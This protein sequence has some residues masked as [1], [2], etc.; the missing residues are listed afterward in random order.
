MEF[1]G[2][3]KFTEAL[4]TLGETSIEDAVVALSDSE[5]LT[6]AGTTLISNLASGITD[7]AGTITTAI[8]TICSTAV[9]DLSATAS[10]F[11]GVGIMMSSNLA[12][13]ISL[14]SFVV[15]HAASNLG[16]SA[17]S[18]VSV[19]GFYTAGGNAAKGFANGI[20]DNTWRATAKARAMAQ[21]AYEAAKKQLDINSP[22]R[23]FI[24]LAGSVPEG[25]AKGI[26]K[27]GGLVEDSSISMAN[28]AI[29]STK[30]AIS[31]IGDFIS[32]DV[33]TQPT[34]RPVIDLTDVR[35]G[36]NSINRMFAMTPSLKTLSNV[37]SISRMMN[38]SQNGTNND[39]ISAIKDLGSRLGTST[40][41]TY[42]INGVTYD[43]GSNISDAVK[44]IV[45][46]ARIER[47]T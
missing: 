3:D 21:K 16:T 14:A 20:S 1:S 38:T 27:F 19:S 34:I 42:Q 2:V 46:A 10:T 37:N 5:K 23:V 12:S 8:N 36:A 31:R 40:G 22:S 45:R 6:T 9:S 39:V 28:K 17:A 25:F 18:S 11:T 43:D 15:T 26:D 41:D 32:S 13:G 4:E 35:A 7:S 33:D 44:A 47:R 24:K 29:N 30:D